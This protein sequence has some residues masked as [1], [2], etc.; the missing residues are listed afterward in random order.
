MTGSLSSGEMAGVRGWARYK[1]HRFICY[2]GFFM[3]D[4]P[5]AAFYFTTSRSAARHRAFSAGVPTEM[6]I[7]SGN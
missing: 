7:H 1:T 6:R 3:G 5:E 2:C 4:R